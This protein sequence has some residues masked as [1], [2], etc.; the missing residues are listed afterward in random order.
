MCQPRVVA[1]LEDPLY[2]NAR[3]GS[4]ESSTEATPYHVVSM[5]G[6]LAVPIKAGRFYV[7]EEV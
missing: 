4:S 5:A 3:C 1:V 2:R 6:S 7:C